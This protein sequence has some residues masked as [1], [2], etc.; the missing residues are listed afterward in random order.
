MEILKTALDLLI[1]AGAAQ[2]VFLALIL[3]GRGK[4]NGSGA[5]AILAALMGLFSL[6]IIHAVFIRGFPDL[7]S[8]STSLVYEPLQFLF[9]PL[10]FFYVRTLTGN[11]Q[12]I[13][14]ADLLHFIPF[15]ALLIL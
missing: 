7:T 8:Y 6:N 5:D 1:G 10:L 14:R 3:A 4:R 12:G 13:G 9:G 11:G 2:G 15:V